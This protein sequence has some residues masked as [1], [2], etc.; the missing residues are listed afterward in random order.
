MAVDGQLLAGP[1]QLRPLDIKQQQLPEAKS[2][3]DLVLCELV[4]VARVKTETRR[5]NLCI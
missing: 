3:L 5:S 1:Q 4:G 2:Q